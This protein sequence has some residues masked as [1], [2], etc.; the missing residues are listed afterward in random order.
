LFGSAAILRYT[1]FACFVLTHVTSYIPLVMNTTCYMEENK[2]HRYWV[3]AACL[4]RAFR[5]NISAQVCNSPSCPSC[6]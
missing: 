1:Y 2:N 6:L 3:H 5:V 4:P